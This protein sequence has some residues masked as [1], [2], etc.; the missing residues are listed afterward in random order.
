MS[1]VTG[2]YTGTRPY[3]VYLSGI[4]GI[5]VTIEGIYYT[6]NSG[7]NWLISNINKPIIISQLSNSYAVAAA[8]GSKYILELI[9]DPIEGLYYTSNYGISWT[10]SN[11]DVGFFDV[12]ELS[13]SNGIA[14]SYTEQISLKNGTRFNTKQVLYT[15]NY[16]VT[17]NV[18]T[19]YPNNFIESYINLVAMY[20]TYAIG[21]ST[22]QQNGIFYTTDSGNNWIQSNITTGRFFSISLDGSNGIAASANGGLLYSTNYGQTW[23]SS[24][25]TTGKFWFTSLSGSN[26][27]ASVDI[28]SNTNFGIFYTTNSGQTWIQSN[29]T[30]GYISTLSLSGTYGVAVVS[31]S[32]ESTI[33]YG[34][35]L[36]SDAGQTWLPTN[37]TTTNK[38]DKNYSILFKSSISG[39]NCTVFSENNTV[40]YLS[41]PLCLSLIHI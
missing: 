15:T 8:C 18:S 20:N 33:P 4:N 23:I 13:G 36:T 25:I 34:I 40:Y 9:D 1:F 17:W 6:A 14:I 26:G 3:Y 35:Y 27:I 19:S 28:S 29:I 7:Q 11:I 12:V 30:N 38:L 41:S 10:L 2:D 5:V 37:L 39:T 24:N 32:I 16:G 21:V 31:N 22:Q